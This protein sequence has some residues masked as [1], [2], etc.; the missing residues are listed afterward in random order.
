MLDN[1]LSAVEQ[2]L[3]TKL[4]SFLQV[5]PVIQK[6][7][8]DIGIGITNTEEWLACY[9]GKKNDIGAVK[10]LKINPLEH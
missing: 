6:M 5:I 10:G 8:P 7:L 4:D 1:H 3:E 9:P 2:K